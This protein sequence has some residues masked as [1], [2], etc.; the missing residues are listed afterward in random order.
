MKINVKFN[1]EADPKEKALHD[2]LK[3]LSKGPGTK[4]IEL[5]A[6]K[7][8]DGN[9]MIMDHEDIDIVIMPT[10][11][12]IIAFPKDNFEGYVYDAQEKLFKF[13]SRKGII[14]P[15]SIQGGNVFMSMEAK[16]VQTEDYNVVQASLLNI[17]KFLD[18]ERPSYLI[19]KAYEE[20][21]ERRLTEPDPEEST[22][23]DANRHSTQKGSM[24]PNIRPYGISSIYRV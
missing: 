21:E 10:Q 23:F 8:L 7:T 17:S 2:K 24:R 6:R 14:D 16:M 3:K 12:K 1:K 9:V 20:E 5:K 19:R 22:E 18:E 13:L 11:S 15:S 4:K